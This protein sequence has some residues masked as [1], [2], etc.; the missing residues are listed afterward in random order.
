MRITAFAVAL[1]L[2]AAP[3]L[4]QTLTVPS[5]PNLGSVTQPININTADSK[6]LG[7]LPGVGQNGADAIIKNRPFSTIDELT[8]KANLPKSVV[9]GI[10]P[11]VTVR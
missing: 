11:L 8:T 1:S 5:V 10:R 9:D 4:A 3:A 6:T 2:L 7:S